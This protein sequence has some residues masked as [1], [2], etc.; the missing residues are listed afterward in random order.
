LEALAGQS[1]Q[2]TVEQLQKGI[3]REYMKEGKVF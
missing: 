3:E 1:H 2:I